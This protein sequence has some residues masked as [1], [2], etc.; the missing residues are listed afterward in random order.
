MSIDVH[1]TAVLDGDIVFEGSNIVIGPYVVLQGNVILG[2]NVTI[3]AGSIIGLNGEHLTENGYHGV[4]IGAGSIIRE[5]VIIHG[6]LHQTT[7]LGNDCFVMSANY[8][9]HD[10][11]LEDGVVL[12]AGCRLA[13]HS[14][15]MK[16]SNL[17]MSVLVHQYSV[18]GSYSMVGMGGVVIKGSRVEPGM[19]YAGNPIRFLSRNSHA[20]ERYEVGAEELATETERFY[21]ML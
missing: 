7:I 6:G 5:N 4:I 10:C 3:G 12:S 9:A 20:L 2:E 11:V 8:I 21:A 18:I 19:K 16:R 17:G 1:Q 14:H 15:L 13:G